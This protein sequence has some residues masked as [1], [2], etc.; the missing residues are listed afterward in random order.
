[1]RQSARRPSRRA[2]RHVICVQCVRRT[3]LPELGKE[4]T[5]RKDWIVG[6]V[7]LSAVLGGLMAAGPV[8][9]ASKNKLEAFIPAA[10]A[11]IVALVAGDAAWG[12]P[13]RPGPSGGPVIP[14]LEGGIEPTPDASKRVGGFTVASFGFLGGLYAKSRGLL[15]T[16]A[17][18]G[19]ADLAVHG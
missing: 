2:Q 3:A 12:M 17:R 16:C 19:G 18:T 4:R 9:A 1:M 7:T 5:M 10:F 11:L 6:S 15:V 14:R 8:R 13:V